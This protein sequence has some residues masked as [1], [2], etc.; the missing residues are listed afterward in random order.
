MMPRVAVLHSTSLRTNDMATKN[1]TT[2]EDLV[3]AHV[4]FRADW[5]QL[6][7]SVRP[8]S[9][10]SLEDVRAELGEVHRHA[11]E[12]FRLE[13]QSEWMT[14]I[15]KRGP[16]LERLVQRLREEHREL[17]EAIDTLL[18]VVQA[19][20]SLDDGLRDKIHNWVEARAAART[21]KT[22][23]FW[24]PTRWTWGR[25]IEQRRVTIRSHTLSTAF[26][27]LVRLWASGRA[28]E[29]SLERWPLANAEPL[30]GWQ[31][32]HHQ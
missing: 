28:A 18:E 9:A 30:E 21:A 14:K 2:A 11:S 5:E 16:K 17:L 10:A 6:A 23:S 7:E 26:P 13:E 29:P 4:A 32:I 19:A 22:I 25:R 8:S 24:K 1:E 3:Q 15:K 31:W 12:H 27:T 20:K